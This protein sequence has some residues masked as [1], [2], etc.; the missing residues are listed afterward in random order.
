MNGFKFLMQYKFYFRV[1]KVNKPIIAA[2]VPR[3]TSIKDDACMHRINASFLHLFS[4]FSIPLAK[5]NHNRFRKAQLEN[6]FPR[7]LAA[8]KVK[9]KLEDF[10][11]L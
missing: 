2:A 11:L 10:I 5:L 4:S 9:P 6:S 7:R 3:T 1:E 8:T